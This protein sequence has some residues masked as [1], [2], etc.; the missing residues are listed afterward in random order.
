MALGRSS[1]L[2]PAHGERGFTLIELLVV[3]VIIGILSAI[4]IPRLLGQ[5]TKATDA[6][7][8][9]TA[10][11]LETAE[12]FGIAGTLTL[13]YA[14]SGS[15]YGILILPDHTTERICQTSTGAFPK[16]NCVAGGAFSVYGYGT[17]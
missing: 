4:A 14:A 5:Q 8:Q 2:D 1:S 9:S 11:V 16:G 17:W 10:R 3:I 15:V 12:P 13:G 7:A 6:S